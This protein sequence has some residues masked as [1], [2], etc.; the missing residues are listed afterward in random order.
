MKLPT[1][2]TG[3]SPE[4][5]VGD[6]TETMLL[7]ALERE[8]LEG[9]LRIALRK[10]RRHLLWMVLGISPAAV[11]PAVGL[12]WEGNL[13]LLV[14][15]GVLVTATQWVS[16]TRTSREAEAIENRLA[17]LAEGDRASAARHAEPTER[18]PG[19]SVSPIGPGPPEE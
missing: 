11:L 10:E 14:L 16:W 3:Q 2:P 8:E 18:D 17:R 9:Q 4:D 1:G 13:G 7:S 15:L 19:D 12:L 5:P 6:L